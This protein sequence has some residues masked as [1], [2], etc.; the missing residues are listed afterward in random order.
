VSRAPRVVIADEQPTVRASVRRLL[1]RDGFAVCREASDADGAV[2]AALRERPDI[3]LKK[4]S[5]LVPRSYDELI[6]WKP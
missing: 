4:V 6:V 5:S 2:E 3:C 1:E